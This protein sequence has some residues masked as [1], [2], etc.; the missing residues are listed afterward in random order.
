MLALTLTLPTGALPPGTIISAGPAYASPVAVGSGSIE[1][2]NQ[3]QSPTANINL[4]SAAGA[5]L[6]RVASPF[7]IETKNSSTQSSTQSQAQQTPPLTPAPRPT[8][9]TVQ[10][11]TIDRHRPSITSI[12]TPTTTTPQ[13]ANTSAPLLA[14]HRKDTS[15]SL[16]QRADSA[17][18][19]LQR[20]ISS[21]SAFSTDGGGKRRPSGGGRNVPGSSD[22]G[23]RKESP[24]EYL[25]KLQKQVGKKEM[26]KLLAQ[27]DDFHSKVRELAVAQIDFRGLAIDAALR[28]FLHFFM[29][30]DESQEIDRVLNTFGKKYH[31]DNPGVFADDDEP[32][33]FA[34][35][36]VI[37]NVDLHNPN[38]RRK[39]TVQQFI[40]NNSHCKNVPI[41]VFQVIYENIK[42]QQLRYAKDDTDPVSGN[43]MLMQTHGWRGRVGLNVNWGGGGAGKE[44][45]EREEG[46]MG[47]SFHGVPALPTAS[48]IEEDPILSISSIYP[49]TTTAGPGTQ[50]TTMT[51]TQTHSRAMSSISI[52]TEAS[53]PALDIAPSS[54]LGRRGRGVPNDA[55]NTGAGAATGA[56][57]N[58]DLLVAALLNP[59]KDGIL[60]RKRDVGKGG[61][62]VQGGLRGWRTY[63]AVLSGSQLVLFKDV[64]WF[65][66]RKK[67]VGA[68]SSEGGVGSSNNASPPTSSHSPPPPTTTTTNQPLKLPRPSSLHSTDNAIALYDPTYTSRTH[69]FRMRLATGEEMLFQAA[70]DEDAGQWVEQLNFVATYKSVGVRARE[71]AGRRKSLWGVGGGIGGT[72]D[73]DE[74]FGDAD[75]RSAVIRMK[76]TTFDNTLPGLEK[77]LLF[78]VTF[79]KHAR[80]L[81]PL[82]RKGRTILLGAQEER[83]KTLRRVKIE[84]E[85]VKSYKR[86]L[87]RDL[88]EG[89]VE[90]FREGLVEEEEGDGD[91]DGDGDALEGGDGPEARSS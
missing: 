23:G 41:E 18:G 65:E 73:E 89:V 83:R 51:D 58:A 34:Y 67:E 75:G 6:R 24:E 36:I 1:Q 10:P 15:M 45:V 70:D 3:A 29:L 88:V 42:A 78:E 19:Q 57:P 11:P 84:L 28:R 77:Q 91:G 20:Q 76:L 17:G 13:T 66:R 35:S 14:S 31:A 54:T 25:R 69:V 61:E 79:Q 16:P 46:E 86:V 2:P 71:E 37:L 62:K 44:E 64:E 63:W 27:K 30:P 56:P 38:N 33:I 9:P 39:M 68:T 80:L 49:A 32:Y 43:L 26:A 5:S 40:S 21:A 4:P 72:G 8:T 87:V 60:K 48:S 59:R 53:F 81:Q 47:Q 82:T 12:P 85:R 22:M 7:D 74:G 50:T 55:G 90:G 52:A